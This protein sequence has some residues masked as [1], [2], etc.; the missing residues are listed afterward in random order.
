[1]SMDLDEF[2]DYVEEDGMTTYFIHP[3]N[4]EGIEPGSYLITV[5]Y[6][7]DGNDVSY[8]GYINLIEIPDEESSINI[9]TD[10]NPTVDVTT[11]EDIEGRLVISMDEE[12][13]YEADL[14][15]IS[16]YDDEDELYHH[17]VTPENYA[18][19]L[20]PDEYT[21]TVAYYDD[22]GDLI[23]TRDFDI[24]IEEEDEN[25]FDWEIYRWNDPNEPN[26]VLSIWPR[27]HISGGSIEITVED[28]NGEIWTSL[29][30]LDDD[31]DGSWLTAD[32]F[33]EDYGRYLISAKYISDDD[34]ETIIFE[35]EE[36]FATNIQVRHE[37][38]IY[39]HDPMF[40]IAI[41]NAGDDTELT[42]GDSDPIEGSRMPNGGPLVWYVPVE[43]DRSG[44]YDVSIALYDEE[45]N[46]FA[47][48]DYTLTVKDIDYNNY[49]LIH[50]LDWD[51][52]TSN[53][54][55]AALYCPIGSEG[56]LTI[57]IY[58]PGDDDDYRSH[59]LIKTITDEIS[60]DDVGHFKEWTLADLGINEPGWNYG[61][62]INV[63]DG[64]FEDEF[65][66][67]AM[68]YHGIFIDIHEKSSLDD[69]WLVD[70]YSPL[71]NDGEVILMIGDEVYFNDT[72]QNL[73]IY[74][75]EDDIEN[76]AAHFH[77]GPANFNKTIE[78]GEYEN[79]VVYY[80]GDDGYETSS[81][82]LDN[83][84][85]IYIEGV[86]YTNLE[87]TV[88]DDPSIVTAKLTDSAGDA[89]SDVIYVSVNG[90]EEVE[91]TTNDDGIAYIKVDGNATVSAY[92]KN[93]EDDWSGDEIRVYVFNV[94][95][96]IIIR[97]NATIDLEKLGNTVLITL[98][99]DDGNPIVGADLSV[100]VNDVETLVEATD[101]SGMTSVDVEG[102]ATVYVVILMIMVSR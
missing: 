24:R 33:I 27:D 96:E 46:F 95:E 42:I 22:E 85:I 72:L 80:I 10:V 44:E 77:F 28:G 63:G 92:Y 23:E 70:I 88:G 8:D 40:I 68:M 49:T 83:P 62:V 35:D 45:G 67:G 99:D 98:S 84:D 55:V 52:F 14:K 47:N 9:D 1:M 57:E 93:T 4:L 11:N 54:T 101:D 89:L 69:D 5:R 81:D 2:M 64:E 17:Y 39:L 37:R 3:D 18:N 87:L 76:Y 59:G 20:Y 75:S 61:F 38:E 71:D 58:G 26:E 19:N 12:I 32:L 7:D 73:K 66:F 6:F 15:E 79:V 90:G 82:K 41:Y 29:R 86:D 102:N 97:P 74:Q 30:Y 56:P 36:F 94:P 65:G 100:Y 43:V 16:S 48:Y 91:Y 53:T 31:Y 34:E 25:D 50:N 60:S 21:I 78:A 13:L 51:Y